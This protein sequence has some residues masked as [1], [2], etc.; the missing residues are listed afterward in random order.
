MFE[1]N[2]MLF[3][4]GKLDT[5]R[6]NYNLALEQNDP[7]GIHDMRVGLKRLKAFFRIVEAINPDFN[8]R[9]RFR[10][11]KKIA[12]AT[13]TLRD[14][15]VQLKLV[16]KMGADTGL[17]IDSF[18]RFIQQK[19]D[20]HRNRFIGFSLSNP[21]KR[22]K[23]SRSAIKKALDDTDYGRAEMR[24]LGRFYNL[25]N[26][27]VFLHRAGSFGDEIL[28]EV[29]KQS[30]ESH[31]T[32]EII[33]DSF[34]ILEDREEF[35]VKISRVHKLLGKWHDLDVCQ[36][37]LGEYRETN[38]QGDTGS[39]SGLAENITAAKEKIRKDITPAFDE[40][41]LIASSF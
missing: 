41:A 4:D 8:A 22:L 34:H 27:L 25:K 7:E 36:C 21:L 15:Q 30:K 40:F 32:L 17:D 24:A 35:I 1:K 16:E 5:V 33:R 9:K 39:L 38:P 19:E 10:N 31:Y 6:R 23:K 13:G 26:R 37:Y 29:R 18:Y 2:M 14:A 11:F 12:R 28:H 20:I 3:F